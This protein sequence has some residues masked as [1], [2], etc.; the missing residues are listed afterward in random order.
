MNTYI[1]QNGAKGATF[2]FEVLPSSKDFFRPFGEKPAFF[3]RF[4]GSP[5]GGMSNPYN[6]SM[7]Y[8]RPRWIAEVRKGDVNLLIAWA[9]SHRYRL[10][11]IGD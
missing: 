9:K 8:T 4:D 1:L 11:L 7:D 10:I 5:C 3:G 2:K 6:I